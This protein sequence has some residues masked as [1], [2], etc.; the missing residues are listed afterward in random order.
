[1]QKLAKDTG[2]TI[3]QAEGEI[4]QRGAVLQWMQAK[5]L[6]NFRET[7]PLFQ[8]YMNDPTAT[9][10]KAVR[11]LEELRASPNQIRKEAKA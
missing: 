8:E 11:E 7:T 5:G 2:I 1:M 3:A 10:E 4:K 9:Y 6:R